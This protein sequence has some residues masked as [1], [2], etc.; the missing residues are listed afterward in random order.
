[1]VCVRR[2]K[3]MAM[4]LAVLS[5]VPA[6]AF[7]NKFP[8]VAGRMPTAS[9]QKFRSAPRN[10]FSFLGGG[11]GDSGLISP[12]KA[13]KGRSQKMPNIEGSRHYVLGTDMTKVPAGHKVAVFANGCFW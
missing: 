4:R 8:T 11:F 9:L 12:Q 13:L 5:I 3:K 1:M 10:L 6:A 7:L 2:Q